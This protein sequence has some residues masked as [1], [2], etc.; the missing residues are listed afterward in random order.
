MTDFAQREH[1]ER[2]PWMT[3]AMCTCRER[4]DGSR[5]FICRRIACNG[6]GQACGGYCPPCFKRRMNRPPRPPV[7]V[8]CG[9]TRFKATW[10]HYEKSLTHDGFIVLSVGDLGTHEGVN[11]PIDPALKE[12]LDELHKRKIDM[13]DR[14]FVLNVDG[15]IGQSTRSEIEYAEWFEKPIDYLVSPARALGI[16]AEQ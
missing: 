16:E 13:A 1:L 8:L 7:V 9:S 15:Y 11:E 3:P 5:Y 2:E 12:R 10:R 14:V 4:P 6:E